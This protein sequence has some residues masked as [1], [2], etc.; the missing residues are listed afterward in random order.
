MNEILTMA[1]WKCI[2]SVIWIL[3][4]SI[5]TSAGAADVQYT[6]C[7]LIADDNRDIPSDNSE[8]AIHIYLTCKNGTEDVVLIDERTLL[9]EIQQ[10]KFIATGTPL[11]F[12]DDLD[13][14]SSIVRIADYMEAEPFELYDSTFLSLP[15]LMRG[16]AS[17]APLTIQNSRVKLTK[18]SFSGNSQRKAGAIYLSQGVNPQVSA[19]DENVSPSLIVEDSLFSA[20]KGGFAGALFSEGFPNI[21]LRNSTFTANTGNAIEHQKGGLLSIANCVF[22][23]KEGPEILRKHSASVLQGAGPATVRITGSTFKDHFAKEGSVISWE[24]ESG[25]IGPEIHLKH[26]SFWE[27]SAVFGGVLRTKGPIT[28]DVHRCNFTD[29]KSSN[30]GGA[31][32]ISLLNSDQFAFTASDSI[33]EV[34]KSPS[35]GAI[36]ILVEES[37]SSPARTSGGAVRFSDV[38]F[39]SNKAWNEDG[40]A[41]RV[42]GCDYLS[43]SINGGLYSSN[44]A[45]SIGGALKLVKLTHLKID[46][47]TFAS[48][49]LTEAGPIGG[50][51][52][53]GNVET[54]VVKETIFENN[55]AGTVN[56]R[57]VA[58]GD[59]GGGGLAVINSN[60]YGS[61]TSGAKTLRIIDST[62][63]E[64]S[65]QVSGGA[66]L[67]SKYDELEISGLS[68]L[69]SK[70]HSAGALKVVRVKSVAIDGSFFNE[71]EA[72]GWDGGA[73]F[74]YKTEAVNVTNSRFYANKASSRGS[75]A[76]A[77]TIQ[78]VSKAI[79]THTEFVNNTASGKAGAAKIEGDDIIQITECQFSDNKGSLGG[80]LSLAGTTNGDTEKVEI[81]GSVF[82]NNEASTKM[83]GALDA[84]AF[85]SMYFKGCQFNSNTAAT[86][87][88]SISVN[89]GGDIT[90][91]SCKI[92]KN[93]AG[94][95]GAG[96]Y[97]SGG[98]D[99]TLSGANVTE[100]EAGGSGGGLYLS[101]VKDLDV[102]GS[103]VERNTAGSAGAGICLENGGNVKV[104]STPISSN[105]AQQGSGVSLDQV[106][107]V[108][109]ENLELQGNNATGEGAAV[110]I[111]GA[112]SVDV[113]RTHA[114]EGKS[115][116]GG[117]FYMSGIDG[118]VTFTSSSF[119]GN[120]AAEDGGALFLEKTG[121]VKMEDIPKL[122]ACVAEGNGGGVFLDQAESLTVLRTT[123]NGGTAKEGAAFFIS[124]VGVV[125]FEDSV[126]HENT[127]VE[128]GGAI[129]A[130]PTVS[131]N[132]TGC[133]FQTNKAGG[134]GGS[135]MLA[136]PSVA[137]LNNVK[138]DGTSAVGN[139]GALSLVESASLHVK[140]ITL[141]GCKANNGG[142]FSLES[143]KELSARKVDFTDA[144]AVG[145]GG[146]L[147]LR[148][149][150]NI[151]LKGWKGGAAIAGGNG[152]ALS[153]VDVGAVSVEDCQVD[154]SEAGESGGA[155]FAS[156]IGKFGIKSIHTSNTKAG[157]GMGGSLALMH[158]NVTIS[159]STITSSSSEGNGGC[160]AV[161]N[162]PSF[163][164]ITSV[165]EDCTSVSGDGGALH[166]PEITEV[167]LI[168]SKFSKGSATG[169][170]GR[171]GGVFVAAS[172]AVKMEGISF[173][174]C[175]AQRG[176]GAYIRDINALP[177]DTIEIKGCSARQGG[178]L[179]AEGVA[180]GG[181]TLSGGLVE[182][183]EASDA[184][185]G[186]VSFETSGSVVIEKSAFNTNTAG[187]SG[188]AAFVR[189]KGT[190]RAS[191]C[192]FTSNSAKIGNGG[193]VALKTTEPV[194]FSQVV[195]DKCVASEG[196]GGALHLTS[197]QRVDLLDVSVGG[198]SVLAAQ[199]GGG[200]SLRDV[201]D[202]VVDALKLKSLKSL[203]DGAGLLVS[204]ADTTKLSNVKAEDCAGRNG[205]G[206]FLQRAGDVSVTTYTSKQV[207]A[208]GDGGAL[209][210]EKSGD[211][212]VKSV[213]VTEAKA[214]NGGG[215]FV[216]DVGRFTA[217]DLTLSEVE[218]TTDGGGVFIFLAPS[219]ETSNVK[220][221]NSKALNG[222][223]MYLQD[224]ATLDGKTLSFDH[225]TSMERG[226]GI[227]VK[228]TG[229]VSLL[230]TSFVGGK[231][232]SGAG[233]WME[234]VDSDK[235]GRRLLEN[236]ETSVL[237]DGATFDG[238]EASDQGGAI[239]A[240]KLDGATFANLDVKANSAGGAGGA[241]YASDTGMLDVANSTFDNN[242]AAEGGGALATN[243]VD[244]VEVEGSTFSHSSSNMGGAIFVANAE[245][246]TLKD[247]VVS[248]SEAEE[249]G[250]GI[251]LDNVGS[252]Q[253]VDMVFKENSASAGG[254]LDIAGG[255]NVHM[256]GVKFE[257]NRA[258]TWE[259]SNIQV[260][261]CDSS[262]Q[263]ANSK[264]G[265]PL[266]KAVSTI[267]SEHSL[268]EA[269]HQNP[270]CPGELIQMDGCEYTYKSVGMDSMAIVIIAVLS[271]LGLVMLGMVVAVMK[272][273]NPL[274]VQEGGANGTEENGDSDRLLDDD[275]APIIPLLAARKSLDM[276]EQGV[277][278]MS[279]RAN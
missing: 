32:S 243:G 100:N 37:D 20:G 140:D 48:N 169:G 58:S 125:S 11:T 188:G 267:T 181:V 259:G 68:L 212:A 245:M 72:C 130:N 71:N 225:S 16:P 75:D 255:G 59:K 187:G 7:K 17:A 29:N 13:D 62:F 146:V 179:L 263:V 190:F 35:A 206:I 177:L 158:L 228:S 56:C 176:G 144:E 87:G 198:S 115:A 232:A 139:G 142:C 161:E 246:V 97:V 95:T 50:A 216:S 213:T 92:S 61:Q 193:A 251:M 145:S 22:N 173:D 239:F 210:L 163:T 203:K 64:N 117:A 91:A 226:A 223:G 152:G 197:A 261:S 24:T 38:N 211:S 25:S 194:T 70:A 54:V 231:A 270:S 28:L 156:G 36:D 166:L 129:S 218:A 47:A 201:G 114:S 79:L 247:G 209:F 249:N 118:G 248:E 26:S 160:I 272:A 112:A 73:A 171:G 279:N 214:N 119:D 39:V 99:V 174:S 182:N 168:S 242:K 175:M 57:S 21:E 167:S 253:A 84:S 65:A 107:D 235:Y 113:L 86:S 143:V 46:G 90:M 83:G 1:H 184:E 238:N 192:T 150:D 241:I 111:T 136:G 128:D 268:N 205:A 154:G 31:M 127:A 233:L 183:N 244:S 34:N 23:G 63:K 234:K 266:K 256:T 258:E 165:L 55:M 207:T 265:V 15:K 257:G 157:K 52:F 240:S 191:D 208:T 260:S 109:F 81:V 89:D 164:M 237:V 252:L 106:K 262:V 162:A 30:Q 135:I 147:D 78:D 217:H 82:E 105:Q 134:D 269:M 172:D 60:V 148:K 85:T 236:S 132:C 53:V 43:M 227:Y 271:C 274:S 102:S 189:A 224:V 45:G 155:I 108:Q 6:K 131:F 51:I 250:G 195:F 222:A 27:N 74:L 123:V 12:F 276:L 103:V 180:E 277:G 4:A 273:R 196:E 96:V 199:G 66:I 202:V 110:R 138:F 124:G 151:S 67:V 120:S 42:Q 2:G 10:E 19:N 219:V 80:A 278:W 221:T 133:D 88:G 215:I 98:G 170:G 264:I 18:C 230:D 76:G 101:S 121:P 8:P 178:G 126:F 69:N 204:G 153:M 94:E 141:A 275:D 9:A 104:G 33:F 149:T 220:V 137:T 229:S 116:K 3:L 77:I 49:T 93:R 122:I 186:G 41:M 44:K 40:G 254:A 5:T 200:I 14:F 159:E 185:G